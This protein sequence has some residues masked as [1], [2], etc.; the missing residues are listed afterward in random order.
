[1]ASLFFSYSRKDIDFARKLTEAFMGQ[2]L[3]FWIDWESIPPTVEWW[4]EIKKGIEEADVFLFLLSPDSAKSRVCKQEIDHAAKNGKRL[5]PIV[6]RDITASE[7]PTELQPLNWIFLREND[8]FG[9]AFSKLMTAIKTDYEWV[10]A[11][12]QLQVKALEWERSGHENSFLLRGKELQDAE[13]QFAMNSSKEPH[14]TNLQHNYVLKSRQATDKQRRVIT[15]IAIAGVIALAA[16]AAFGFIQ[17]GFARE[18]QTTAEANLVVAQTAQEN[19]IYKQALADSNAATAVANE[20]E[21]KRQAHISRAGELASLAIIEKDKHFDLALLFGLEAF[22]T[23]ETSR[24]KGTLLTLI[25]SH[26]ALDRYIFGHSS[27]IYSIA[28]NQEGQLL[29]SASHYDTIVTLWDISNPTDPS[30]LTT[31][32]GHTNGISSVAFSPDGNTLAS[33]S[34]DDT[35]ILW[36]VSYPTAPHQLAT[37]KAH[38]NRDVLSVAFSPDGETLASGSADTTV[39]LW[40]VRNPA[41][42]SRLTTLEGHSS[43]V[44]SI[45]FSPDGET[46]ASGSADATIILWNIKDINAPSQFTTLEGHS[47]DVWGVAVSPDGQI[48]ASG[49]ADDTSI[50][51]NIKNPTFPSQLTTLEGYSDWVRNVAFSPDG[52]TLASGSA[53]TTVTLWDVRDPTT[54]SKIRTLEGHSSDVWSITFSPDGKILAS[55]GSFDHTIIL[56]DVINP[57]TSARLVKLE[58]HDESVT[59]VAFSPDGETLAS[60]S[61]DN[62]IILWDVSDPIIPSQLVTLEGHSESVLSVVFSSDG[63]TLVSGSADNTIILWDM[64]PLSWVKK[65]CQRVGR[66]FTQTEWAQ[67]FPNEEY[68]ATCLEWPLESET[69]LTPVP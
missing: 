49:S 20:Q 4:E 18:A 2:D 45:A 8:N 46:L 33:A 26:P 13:L 65:A 38:N 9:D 66:N 14:P 56:W 61:A 17:A 1:M 19:A 60:G 36:D 23:W 69:M 67:Y 39:I 57:F 6:V 58:R 40:D 12:R 15:S 22:N 32:E 37:L 44:W 5:I 68:R 7:A 34:Y 53:D 3:D 59:S 62:T 28:F 52:E 25:D 16:L 63:K 21:A 64:D 42:P 51:W 54:P 48:L 29:A 35:V 43:D 11:H 41:A 31:L 27:D 24:T 55:A 10:Q 30:Q 50:L 47:S